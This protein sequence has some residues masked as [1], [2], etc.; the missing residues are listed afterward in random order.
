MKNKKVK[1]LLLIIGFAIIFYLFFITVYKKEKKIIATIDLS[2]EKLIPP[3]PSILMRFDDLGSVWMDFKNT[4]I[5]SQLNGFMKWFWKEMPSESLGFSK[6]IRD[7]QNSIGFDLS[8]KNMLSIL[9][10][11]IMVAMWLKNAD[12]RKILLI[13]SLDKQSDLLKEVRDLVAK[14]IGIDEYKNIQIDIFSEN[15][16]WCLIDDRLVISNDIFTI[17]KVIDLATDVLN[18]SV[19]DDVEFKTNMQK[20]ISGNYIYIKPGGIGPNNYRPIEEMANAVLLSVQFKKG[21]LVK[22]YIFNKNPGLKKKPQKIKSLSF[23]PG[24]ALLFV[25]GNLPI[26]YFI[27]VPVTE[28][29]VFSEES[30]YVLCPYNNKNAIMMFC[31]VK[32][33]KLFLGKFEEIVKP[34]SKEKEGG[35]FDYRLPFLGVVQFKYFFIKKY[36]IICYPP[37]FSEDIESFMTKKKNLLSETEKFK[38]LTIPSKS[39][40]IFYIDFYSIF[41]MLFKNDYLRFIQPSGGYTVWT[42]VGME[43]Y[44]YIPMVDLSNQQCMDIFSKLRDLAYRKI[45]IEK[46]KVTQRNLFYLREAINIYNAKTRKY[47]RKLDSLIEEYLDEIPQELLTKSNKVSRVLNGSGGWVYKKGKVTLN[48]FGSDLSGSLYTRW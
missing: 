46:E 38:Q 37:S 35:T 32:S 33:K 1:I 11:N 19:A 34:S 41:S 13:S 22:S 6:D 43:N 45:I 21:I 7:I 30:G 25:A 12:D 16:Y 42:P 47:P 18:S 26:P 48:V 2:Y 39:N 4:N 27:P 29:T 15:K 9:S 40:E 10:K 31:K 28:K 20:I 36:F 8:E 14:K 3:D 44:Y 5:Y 17:R 24:N 23:I